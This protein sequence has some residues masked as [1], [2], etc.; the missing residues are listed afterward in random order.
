[1]AQPFVQVVQ[2]QPFIPGLRKDVFFITINTNKT[3]QP[4]DAIAN[5]KQNFEAAIRTTF[6]TKW[7]RFIKLYPRHNGQFMNV[8]P[9]Y[10]TNQPPQVTIGIEVGT[11]QKRIHAHIIVEV[12]STGSPWLYLNEQSTDPPFGNTVYDP[13]R[14][15]LVDEVSESQFI[16]QYNWGKEWYVNM[17]RLVDSV[18]AGKNYIN[19]DVKDDFL[20]GDKTAAAVHQETVAQPRD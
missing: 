9:R 18:A 13:L 12:P 15:S 8:L 6:Q 17:R 7:N 10:I 11:Q 20:A 16:Q 5:V 3:L 1:M 14:T 19:K 2:Q 4:G